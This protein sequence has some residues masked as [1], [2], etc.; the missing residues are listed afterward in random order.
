MSSLAI[1]LRAE[2]A[3][4]YRLVARCQLVRFQ[5]C[6]KLWAVLQEYLWAVLPDR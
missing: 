6:P 4:R 3:Q 2:S 1:L 5:V